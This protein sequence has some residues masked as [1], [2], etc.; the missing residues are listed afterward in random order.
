MKQTYGGDAREEAHDGGDAD[1]PPVVLDG[2][3]VQNSEHRCEPVDSRV[4]F[5]AQQVRKAKS[6][7]CE[8]TKEYD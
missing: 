2:E 8:I 5:A 6:R 7:K 1:Q 4:L 3:A